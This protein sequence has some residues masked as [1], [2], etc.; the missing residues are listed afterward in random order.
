MNE[1]IKVGDKVEHKSQ[2][3]GGGAKRVMAV[4]SIESGKVTCAWTTHEGERQ[5]G[6]FPMVE[7]EKSLVD[8]YPPAM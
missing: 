5:Q 2:S 4:V 8:E 3:S 1:E 6:S 7:L